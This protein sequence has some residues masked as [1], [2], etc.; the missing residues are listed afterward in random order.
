[1]V[2]SEEPT[3]D[4]CSPII[5]YSL[6][7]FKTNIEKSV[8][9]HLRPSVLY[10]VI[11]VVQ[12]SINNVQ[13]PV[14]LT[15]MYLH[16]GRETMNLEKPHIG[17]EIILVLLAPH[18]WIHSNCSQIARDPVALP[19]SALLASAFLSWRQNHSIC[20]QSIRCRALAGWILRS[21][22]YIITQYSSSAS[23]SVFILR[24]ATFAGDAYGWL[25]TAF[26]WER[27]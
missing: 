18:L 16:Y 5:N 2:N 7:L 12:S 25:R 22:G 10:S 24:V 17:P 4:K 21:L 1:M 23:M 14:N 3:T 20:I 6:A 13:F 11:L 8:Q 9:H 26:S 27:C 19:Q 15:C